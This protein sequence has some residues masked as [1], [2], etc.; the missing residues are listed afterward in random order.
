[1]TTKLF[2]LCA[3]YLLGALPFGYIIV[4]ALVGADVRAAGSG[5]TGATNVTRRA[6]LK[7]GAFTYLLDV[8]KGAAAVLLMC[9]VADDPAWVGAA[10][11]A[12]IIGHMYP[13]FLKFKGGKG[14]AT[15][16]GAYL[17]IVPF[18]VLSTLLV[19]IAIFWKTRM[20]SLASIVATALVPL[21]VYLWYGLVLGRSGVGTLAA[22]VTVGCLLVIAKH[23]ENVRRLLAG[24]ESR[25]DGSKNK[26]AA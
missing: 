26:E 14:V 2:A 25:F 3:S 5:S 15:G 24:T 19:W 16:V 10:A 7:A 17:V 8:A 6:G 12:A 1:M 11:A 23:H 22:S 13:V 4:K 21:W 9:S 18:A 20:V